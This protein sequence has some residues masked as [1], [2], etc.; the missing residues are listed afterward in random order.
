MTEAATGAADGSPVLVP[1]LPNHRFDEAAL[2]RYLAGR[3]PGFAGPCAVRQFQGG[4]S[5]PTFHLQA[6][7]GQ[8]VLRKKPPGPLLPSA[9]AVDREYRILGALRNS[10]VPVPIVHLLCDDE[11]VIGTIFFV[12]DYQPGRVFP[13]RALP[14]VAPADRAAIYGDM[15]RVLALLHGVDWRQAGLEGFGRPEN[16]IGRQID[17]WSK[18]YVGARVGEEPAMDRLTAWLKTHAPVPD[19]TAIA[20]GDYRLGNL[21][22]HPNEPRVVAVLDWELATLG[23]P[24][25]DLAYS[26]LAWRLPP[27]LQGIQGMDVPGLPTEAEYVQAYCRRTGRAGTPDMEFFIAFSLFRW[28]AIAAGVYRRALDG[29][30]ADARGRE[31]GE[32]FR[33]LAE[34]GWNVARAA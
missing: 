24:L 7:S 30:A 33:T 12:M 11:S 8:Y 23:H 25:A 10:G 19:E 13:D 34:Y 22:I 1:V 9:H 28:A 2:E 5:N 27:D 32:K 3:L 6:A 29:T 26:C 20:H 15:G 14:G 4:Q 18:Q 31:A 16:Y 21:I 17:R